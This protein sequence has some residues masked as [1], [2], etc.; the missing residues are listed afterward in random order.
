VVQGALEA[1]FRCVRECQDESE[2]QYYRTVTCEAGEEAALPGDKLRGGPGRRFA[3]GE[4]EIE[5]S[6]T[7]A[8]EEVPVGD[9]GYQ[10]H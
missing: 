2:S 4:R 3:R 8:G 10:R 5:L 1:K 6:S 9:E 7:A